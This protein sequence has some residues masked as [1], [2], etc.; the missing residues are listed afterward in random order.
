MT[1]YSKRG[2]HDVKVPGYI[3]FRK[4]SINFN[5][6]KILMDQ[7]YISYGDKCHVINFLEGPLPLPLPRPNPSAQAHA[8]YPKTEK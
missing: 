7:F 6:E 3:I 1:S 4:Q 2:M 5:S 8:H